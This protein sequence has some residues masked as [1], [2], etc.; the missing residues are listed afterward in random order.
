MASDTNDDVDR[1]FSCFKCG[2]SPPQSAFRERRNHKERIKGEASKEGTTITLQKCENRSLSSDKQKQA[3]NSTAIK[4]KKGN[5]ISPVVFYGSPQGIPVKKPAH[6]LR[7]LREIRLDLK[8]QNDLT[9]SKEIWITFPRQEE[10][11]R[12]K[13]MDKKL[14]HHYEVIQDGLPCH[15][16]F[17]LEFEK[18]INLNKNEDEMVDIFIQVIFEALLEKYSVHGS[19]DWIV[20]L[21]SSTDKKFSRHLIIR[22]PNIA[23]KDNSHVGAFVSEISSRISNQRERNPEL[24]KLY[25]NKESVTENYTEHLFMDPA[26]SRKL[27]ALSLSSYVFGKSPFPALDSFIESIASIGNIS[28]KIRCWYWFSEYGLMNH[29]KEIDESASSCNST[30]WKEAVN[31]ADRIEKMEARNLEDEI[32]DDSEWWINAEKI[33][34]QVEEQKLVHI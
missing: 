34:T 25:I 15:M 3:I 22:I 1:L 21:E 33:V 24:N 16:Y 19:E 23:F 11:I 27:Y 7:L 30:W 14:R 32:G 5:R 6:L 29:L 26:I 2:V 10:A 31:F 20:E 8:K 17:D 13:D 12:Y 18:K 4:L 28:G 9:P